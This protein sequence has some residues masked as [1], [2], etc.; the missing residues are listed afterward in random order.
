VKVDH[1]IAARRLVRP[2][3]KVASWKLPFFLSAAV[4][5]QWYIGAPGH[6]CRA[7]VLRVALGLHNSTVM[8]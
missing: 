6:Y 5:G 4:E 8:M 2:F 3:G 7:G 1:T